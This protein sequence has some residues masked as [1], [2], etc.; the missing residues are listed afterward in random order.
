M[1]A[2][3]FKVLI[4]TFNLFKDDEASHFSKKDGLLKAIVLLL[5]TYKPWLKRNLLVQE[6]QIVF[7]Q[8]KLS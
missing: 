2:L 1:K 7:D 4:W 8:K 3:I 5:L 6:L